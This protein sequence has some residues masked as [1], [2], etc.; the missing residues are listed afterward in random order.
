MDKV[1][2]N[3]RSLLN[4]PLHEM[5]H[6]EIVSSELSAGDRRATEFDLIE[7]YSV[8]PLTVRRV[9]DTLV[10]EGLICRQAWGGTFVAHTSLEHGWSRIAGFTADA[11]RRGFRRSTKVLFSGLAPAAK[12]VAGKLNVDAGEQL[13]RSDRLCLANGESMSLEQS[14]LIREHVPD[15]L[16]LKEA[17]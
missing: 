7:R 16:E 3:S 9:F 8:S 17:P 2:A 15:I 11:Q 5:F 13:A 6:N 10:S 4:H 12:C 1:D 14:S